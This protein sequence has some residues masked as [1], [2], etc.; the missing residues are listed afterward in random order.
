[1]LTVKD[2]LSAEIIWRPDKLGFATPPWASRRNIWDAW[3]HDN[4]RDSEI[5]V[6]N[7]LGLLCHR[8]FK[9]YRIMN[10]LSSIEWINYYSY[11]FRRGDIAIICDPWLDRPVFNNGWSLL[12]KSV[13]SIEQF[14]DITHIWCSHEHPDHFNVPTLS[15]IDPQHRSKISV[16]YQST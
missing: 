15:K 12:S 8:R 10:G 16:L 11:V 5:P 7:Q 3:M 6:T 2:L 13:C 9:S 14:K 4:F 1:R